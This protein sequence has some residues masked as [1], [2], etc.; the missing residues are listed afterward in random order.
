M[1]HEC[2][3]IPFPLAARVG[4]VRRCAEVLQGAANQASRDA[5]WRKTVNSLGER[6]EAIGLHEN[7]IQSQLN[8]FRHAVQQEHL[9]RDYIAMSA[10]KA[11]D[12]AA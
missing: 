8:Q 2:Q 1:T 7:E 9:R 12:G 10:D 6:L 5:Y 3:L 11:P 4:K